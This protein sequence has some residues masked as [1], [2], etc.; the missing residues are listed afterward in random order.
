MKKILFA[1]MT[2]AAMALASCGSSDA[3]C[4]DKGSCANDP[5][6]TSADIT[7]CQNTLAAACGGQYQAV[8]N[9]A[10]SN[11]KCDATGSMDLT[12]LEASCGTQISNLTTCCMSNPTACSSV[13]AAAH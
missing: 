7:S 6:P 5:A 11:E 3:S 12:A 9:C 8:I 4:S 2:V 13:S 10:K 1:V